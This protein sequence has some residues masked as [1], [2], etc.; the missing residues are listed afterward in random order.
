MRSNTLQ[1]NILIYDIETMAAKVYTWS[2]WQTNVIAT[3]EDWYLLSVAWKWKDDKEIKFKRKSKKKGD[4]KSLVKT[5]W[6]LFD[7]ADIVVAHNG[8]SFDQRMVTARFIELGLGPPS[9]YQSVDTKKVIAHVARNYS[10][11][12]DE[13]ARRMEL[14]RKLDTLGF[15]TWLGCA[16]EDEAS[17]KIMEEYNRHDVVLLEQVYYKILPWADG[18]VNMA[19]WADGELACKRCGSQNVQ[20]RGVRRTNASVFQAYRCNK[21]GGWSRSPKSD[22]LRKPAVR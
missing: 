5:I 20:R 16:A 10:N 8:D 13:I 6:R 18:G 7:K 14:G 2:Q 12:L 15:Q 4:D 11:K 9:P 3:D 1:P 21:C 19:H 22:R 17:W